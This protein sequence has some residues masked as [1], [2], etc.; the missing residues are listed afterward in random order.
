MDKKLLIVST[1]LFLFLGGMVVVAQWANYS[2]ARDEGIADDAGMIF[3]VLS[4]NKSCLVSVG[5]AE[6]ILRKKYSKLR[7]KDPW[8]NKYHIFCKNGIV[9]KV[10]SFGSDEI[11]ESNDDICVS[12]IGVMR[13]NEKVNWTMRDWSAVVQ[14]MEH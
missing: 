10:C 1:V 2:R 4:V 11:E 7:T 6:K 3:T 5:K 9:E 13:G 12:D 8:E 14:N